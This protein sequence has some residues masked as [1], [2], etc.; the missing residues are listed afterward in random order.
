MNRWKGDYV[1]CPS[2]LILYYPFKFQKHLWNQVHLHTCLQAAKDPECP[3]SCQKLRQ[4]HL[5]MIY[6]PQRQKFRALAAGAGPCRLSVVRKYTISILYIYTF[7]S[8]ICG[9]PKTIYRCLTNDMY[10]WSSTC[11]FYFNLISCKNCCQ[12]F[13]HT[14]INLQQT[15]TLWYEKRFAWGENDFI[16]NRNYCNLI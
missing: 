13:Q 12:S 15:D 6:F 8:H 16:S 9:T 2:G 14:Y 4:F 10:S 3:S 7:N 11:D 1:D 5:L